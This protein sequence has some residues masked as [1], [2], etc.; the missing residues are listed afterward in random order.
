MMS[1]KIKKKIKEVKINWII[2]TGMELEVMSPP[3]SHLIYAYF[4][5]ST[6]G[7]HRLHRS[8]HNG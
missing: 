3:S 6:P 8:S 5:L 4:Y 1:Q 7:L 2:K